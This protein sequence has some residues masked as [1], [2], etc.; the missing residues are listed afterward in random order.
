MGKY[1]AL[2]SQD[3]ILF[4]DSSQSCNMWGKHLL[5]GQISH[6]EVL[7][8][9]WP[10]IDPQAQNMCSTTNLTWL[11][12]ENSHIDTQ[13]YIFNFRLFFPRFCTPSRFWILDSNGM[14]LWCHLNTTHTRT[15]MTNIS[16]L[17]IRLLCKG[18]KSQFPQFKSR[19]DGTIGLQAMNLHTQQN[20][21]AQT[22][23]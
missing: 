7:G 8:P 20:K 16:R 2:N 13:I 18:T 21:T 19:I 17:S 10:Q 11:Y 12:Q 14:I 23:S 6:C 4:L 5:V 22:C 15:Q 9:R 1:H 3:K